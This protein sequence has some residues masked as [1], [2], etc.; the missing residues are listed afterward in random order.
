[1]PPS[2]RFTILR[3]LL[4]AIGLSEERVEELLALIDGWLSGDG[5][6]NGLISRPLSA[7]LTVCATIS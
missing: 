3:R 5:D 6:D 7:T 4:R 2:D 1:M